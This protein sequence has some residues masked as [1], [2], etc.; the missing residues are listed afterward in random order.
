MILRRSQGGWRFLMSEV[1]LYG[2]KQASL[3]EEGRGRARRASNVNI[4]VDFS[5]RELPA[6]ILWRGW[7]TRLMRL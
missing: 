3:P 6:Q 4:W 7:R 1:P 2:L 5:K